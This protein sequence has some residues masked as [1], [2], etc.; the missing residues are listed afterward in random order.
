MPQPKYTA[1]VN[2]AL[3]SFFFKRLME[4]VFILIF[5]LSL[6]VLLSL[7]TYSAT[8]ASWSHVKTHVGLI[9][10]AGGQTGAYIAD[11]LYRLL[12]YIAYVIPLGCAYLGGLLVQESKRFYW[13]RAAFLLRMS[14]LLFLILG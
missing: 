14:G 12:G 1:R 10:N 11:I 13:N 9:Q 4:G 3:P 8:D 2:T 7:I 6:Y 5:A